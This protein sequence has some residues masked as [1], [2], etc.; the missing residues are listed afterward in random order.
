MVLFDTVSH[1]RLLTE[2]PKF[3]L[4]TPSILSGRLRVQ[5]ELGCSFYFF[6]L[7]VVI[8]NVMGIKNY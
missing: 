3:K 1:D 7:Y 5:S 4:I 2:V 6:M 8:I